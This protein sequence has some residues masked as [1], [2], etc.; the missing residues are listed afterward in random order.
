MADTIDLQKVIMDALHGDPEAECV[1][2]Y[3]YENGYGLEVD[4]P[5]ALKWYS[6]AAEK[7]NSQA[8]YNLGCCYAAGHGVKIDYGKAC[9]YWQIAANLGHPDAIFNLGS[10]YY[11]GTGVPK[12]C[13]KAFFWFLIA[14]NLGV[15]D[16]QSALEI[17]A[18]SLNQT[19]LEQT[20]NE[21]RDWYHQHIEVKA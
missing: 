12:D 9:E 16:A 17:V 3:C 18:P 10:S 5:E 8:I 11:D 2:G 14:M 6:F 19:Q 13:G 20:Q 21:A 15:E 4:Y 1:F 7:G